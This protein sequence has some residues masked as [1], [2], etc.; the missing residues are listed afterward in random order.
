MGLI[1][2]CATPVLANHVD[3]ANAT[4]TCNAYSFSVDASALSPGT[5][6]EISYTIETSPYAGPPITGVIPFTASSTTT[7]EATVWGSFPAL[8]GSYNFYG[9]ASL[10]GHNTVPIL[11]SPTSLSCGAPPPP[12]NSGKGIDTVSFNGTPIVSGDYVWFNANFSVKNIPKTGGVITFT[13][14]RILDVETN[15]LF[16]SAAPNAQI[17]FSPTATCSSTTFSTMTNTWITTVPLKGDDEIFLTGV[18]IPVPSH[19]VP[20]GLTSPGAERSIRLAHQECR[21]SGSGARRFIRASRPIPM[22]LR[23]RR[24]TKAH[25]VRAM[26]ITLQLRRVSITG[27]KSGRTL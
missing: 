21:L 15:S 23:S 25:A 18:A 26:G 7:F 12:P 2:L 27:I 24:V 9:T 10:V 13:N 20:G 17:T 3:T 19:G 1:F 6:Y 22:L 8:I 14:S 4:V 11:F 5:K 16:T